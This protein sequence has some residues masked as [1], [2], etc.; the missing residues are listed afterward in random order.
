MNLNCLAL[1]HVQPTICIETTDDER[2][3]VTA[4]NTAQIGNTKI[5][6]TD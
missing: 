6:Q 4:G 3:A 1:Q 5:G 2:M